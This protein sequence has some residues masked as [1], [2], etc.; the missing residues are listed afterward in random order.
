MRVICAL[1]C[2]IRPPPFLIKCHHDNYETFDPFYRCR[3]LEKGRFIYLRINAGKNQVYI[4]K[5][6]HNLRLNGWGTPRVMGFFETCIG[7]S[8]KQ[9]CA[10]FAEICSGAHKNLGSSV[11]GTEFSHFYFRQLQCK[12]LIIY[13]AQSPINSG[14]E[15]YSFDWI[16]FYTLM[17]EMLRTTNY[18][19]IHK[20]SEGPVIIRW[21][22]LNAI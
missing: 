10:R 12:S 9:G 6:L 1:P 4:S 3:Y 17:C 8:V 22:Q 2:K 13:W 21:H 15:Y 5:Y 11:F 18:N 19:C 20:A 14:A 7:K 16:R